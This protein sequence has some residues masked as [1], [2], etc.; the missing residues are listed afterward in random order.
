MRAQDAPVVVIDTKT[1]E[2]WPIWVEIDSNA[3][4]PE[5]T[6][7]LIHP[8]TNYDAG[9]RYVVAMRKLKDAPATELEPARGLPLPTATTCR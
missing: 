5:R 9:H 1:G 3:S 7:L 2:R 6:S 8:A 4:T